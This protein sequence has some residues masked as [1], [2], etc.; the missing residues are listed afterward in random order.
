MSSILTNGAA[1][2]AL[3]TLRAISADLGETQRMVSSGLRVDVA[4]DNAAYWSISTTMRAD[5][6]AVSAVADALGL[7]AAKTDTAYSGMNAVIDVLAEFKAKLVAAKEDGVDKAK[8]QAELEQLKAQVQG[9]STSSSFNGQNWLNT[10][11]EQIY[12]IETNRASVISS[13]VRSPSGVSTG[14]MD[15][16]LDKISLFNSTGGGLL[17]ADPRDVK[18]LGGM[19]SLGSSS[20]W[21]GSPTVYHTETSTEWMHPRGDSG[22][23]A[24]FN[25]S[26][27]DGAPLDF[28]TPGAE[29]KFDLILD[30]E[31]DPSALT[32]AYGELYDLPGPYD[33]GYSAASLTITKATVDAYN[34]SWGGIVSTNEQFADLLNSL[35]SPHGASVSG[36]FTKEDPPGSNKFV[37]D[38]VTM[39]I[40]T[41]QIHGNGNYVEIA[42]LSSVGV[43][44]GGLL[45]RY[46]YGDR[47][48]GIA[49]RFEQFTLHIDGDN[50]DGVEVDFRFSVNG[51]PATTHNFNRTY[52]N[53]LLGKDTGTVE[54]AEEMVTLLKS[55]IDPDW[56][57]TI[58]EVSASDPNYII[59]KSDPSVD[60]K[61]GPSTSIGFS[62]IVVSIEPIPAM[63][64][65]NIDIEQNP[66]AVDLYIDYI[67]V[68]SQRVVAGAS[69]LGSLSMR[70]DMQTEFTAKLMA[71]TDRGVGRLVDADMNEASTRLKAL[72]TQEQLAIQ[73]LSIAN[74]STENVIQLFR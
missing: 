12:D 57:N 10:N 72:Q 21:S 73:S 7:G 40:S 46:D 48:S 3:Q 26:F 51:A 49:L 37:R 66:G 74:A 36:R 13:F 1:I 9:I 61:W 35:L 33:P 24:S 39:L 2:S 50:A 28:N 59:V 20:T 19:R 45:N 67:E 25:M 70:I 56:P 16:H 5:R 52:I 27:P 64:F 8:V 38:P 55:L 18:T 68:A 58:I 47:G 32:G 54:T 6:M 34:A 65:L 15:V 23:N 41:R 17:Q 71:A 60:R 14:T 22:D 63:N 4:A 43:S 69:I 30:K 53:D 11:I 42:N 62:N 31:Y 44:T 29:I